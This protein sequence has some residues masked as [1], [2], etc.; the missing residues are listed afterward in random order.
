MPLDHVLKPDTVR[1][2]AAFTKAE[3]LDA[4][5]GRYPLAV[6][7]EGACGGG[8]CGFRLRLAGGVLQPGSD[9]R[10][11]LCSARS[12]STRF[13]I[14]P[15]AWPIRTSIGKV[16]ALWANSTV[17]PSISGT[18]FSEGERP[19]KSWWMKKY[20]RTGSGRRAE[21]SSAGR[22]PSYGNPGPWK[23]CCRR[24]ACPAVVGLRRD[25]E[26]LPGH[27][28]GPGSSK[29]ECPRTAS[30]SPGI[31]RVFRRNTRRFTAPGSGIPS[32]GGAA[33]WRG[34]P[35]GR[36]TPRRRRRP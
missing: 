31:L 9:P 7:K 36:R 32:C 23:S 29:Y 12:C 24:P 6:R 17:S 14:Q 19:D 11:R 4:L 15:D 35:A 8:L 26:M 33:G 3:L 16:A 18:N 28:S 5:P 2:L 22:G 10:G 30:V 21:T 27:G 34:P 13:A 25:S 20:A 1:G